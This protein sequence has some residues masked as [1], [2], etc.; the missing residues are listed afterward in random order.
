MKTW[1]ARLVPSGLMAG[2]PVMAG[3]CTG[4]GGACSAAAGVRGAVRFHRVKFYGPRDRACSRRQAPSA[5]A[6]CAT[7]SLSLTHLPVR[8][9][10]RTHSLTHLLQYTSKYK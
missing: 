8:A 4:G 9:Y 5:T 3:T 10:L 6:K 2:S 7:H 1:A